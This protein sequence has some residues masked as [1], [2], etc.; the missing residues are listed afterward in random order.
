MNEA[1]RRV[2]ED[3]FGLSYEPSRPM[4]GGYRCRQV[5]VGLFVN[6]FGEVY[7]CNGLGR[8][9]GHIRCDSLQAVWDAKFARHVRAPLQ[10]GFCL[11]RE[12]V[13]DTV[14]SSGLER[15]LQLY[16]HFAS[17]HG[18]DAVIQRGLSHATGPARDAVVFQNGIPSGI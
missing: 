14:E 7:D 1:V 18:E 9:L 3:E 16:R 15:K 12:R 13:W 17:T 6:L 10:D 5:N 2:D 11:L 4:T 8:F